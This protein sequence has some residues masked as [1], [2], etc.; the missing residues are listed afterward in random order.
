MK[1]YVVYRENEFGDFEILC[2][3]DSKYRAGLYVNQ[4]PLAGFWS[5]YYKEAPSLQISHA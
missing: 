2:W 4:Q 5:Y 1:I 3:T